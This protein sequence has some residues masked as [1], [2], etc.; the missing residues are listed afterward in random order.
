MTLAVFP[1]LEGLE[2]N[3]V[4][5]PDFKTG[6]FE[7]LSGR[8]SRI[9]HRQYPKYTFR[10]SVE[11]LI[12]NREE[13]QL[14]ELMGFMLQRGG[15]YEAFLYKD[16]NDNHVDNQLIGAGNG[17]TTSF[18]LVRDYGGFT[19]PVENINAVASAD[20]G[21]TPYIYVNGDRKTLT[22]DYTVSESGLITF[23]SAPAN[24]AQVT[25][26]IDY[27]YRVRFLAD[28]YDFTQFMADLHECLDIEFIGSVR[29][30]V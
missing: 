25:A 14:K 6:V 5:R 26:T 4:K 12:E 1:Q 24:G 30:I 3:T 2:W 20:D 11:F 13:A 27:Y 10:V 16:P 8:E 17:A 22:T 21:H 28:G 15:M 29:S 7:S 19:E 23:V 18:Q 9:K